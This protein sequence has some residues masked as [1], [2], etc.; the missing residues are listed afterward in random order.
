MVLFEWNDNYLTNIKECD[1]QHKR[2]VGLINELHEKM[3]NGE[4]KSYLEKILSELLDYTAYHFLTEESL[5]ERYGYPEAE[6]HIKEHEE[7]TAK[8]KNFYEKF[9]KGETSIAI[10]LSLFLKD[11]LI[12]HTLYSDK[13][14]GLFLM[15]ENLEN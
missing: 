4:S 8:A 10:S 14:Y 11:W 1:D 2:L 6:R 7:L 12:N 13:K 3:K 5:F 15:K 9:S